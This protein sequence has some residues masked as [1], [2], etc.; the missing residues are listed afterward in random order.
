MIVIFVGNSYI[1]ELLRDCWSLYLLHGPVYNDAKWRRVG[2]VVWGH[3]LW[4]SRQPQ[5]GVTPLW[6]FSCL[7]SRVSMHSYNLVARQ[8]EIDAAT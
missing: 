8:I 6:L 2:T 7:V 5:A 4:L 1:L 3:F